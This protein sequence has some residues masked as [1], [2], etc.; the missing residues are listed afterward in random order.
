MPK[1]TKPADATKTLY[2]SKSVNLR[3][4]DWRLLRLVARVR[5]DAKGGRDSVSKVVESL[6]DGSRKRLES[7]IRKAPS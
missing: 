3:N 5:A 4:A 7:E 6:I 1:Q 2:T